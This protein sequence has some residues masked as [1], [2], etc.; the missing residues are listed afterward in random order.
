LFAPHPA[1]A[2]SAGLDAAALLSGV[3]AAWLV[4][5]RGK[6]LRGRTRPGAGGARTPAAGSISGYVD[7]GELTRES[8]RRAFV[9]LARRIQAVV[10][11]QLRELRE[12][13]ARHGED[14]EVFGDLLAVDHAT[15]LIGRLA[16]SLAVLGGDRPGR[17]WHRPIRVIGV[18][19]GAMSRI[20]EYRR[21]DLGELPEDVAIDGA[22]VEALVHALAELLDNAVRYSPPDSRV[23]LTA[24]RVGDGLAIEV[25]DAG[26]G[27][28]AEA[29]VRAEL[30]LSTE[31][32]GL[33]LAALG[34]A[35]RLG[36]AVV[37]RL[38]RAVGF[39]ASLQS[40]EHGGVRAVILVPARLLSELTPEGEPTAAQDGRPPH[41]PAHRAAM[42]PS[43]VH[44]VAVTA[45]G[46]PQ[47][48]RHVPGAEPP[49]VPAPVQPPPA[50]DVNA[51]DAASARSGESRASAVG[52]GLWLGAFQAGLRGDLGRPDLGPDTGSAPQQNGRTP[53]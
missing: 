4:S 50:S 41:R 38:A 19:R 34:D 20:T 7:V 14:A 29:S 42:Q 39:E 31:D 27:L 48:R 24:T 33:E 45:H 28:G 2:A 10:N 23:A 51:S 12:M 49:P 32:F 26:V 13:E 1:R 40:A 5:R 22:A 15:A 16:D 18:L 46:L 9:N 25:E 35:P 36:L 17:R 11:R 30:M 21:V 53:A 8:A 37:G 52:P 6:A 47:R 3:G 44:V 43:E